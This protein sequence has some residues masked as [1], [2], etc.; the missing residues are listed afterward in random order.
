MNEKDTLKEK[1]MQEKDINAM[2]GFLLIGLGN[3]VGKNKRNG[4]KN[5]RIHY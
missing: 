1:E 4:E 2:L 5:D 3:I